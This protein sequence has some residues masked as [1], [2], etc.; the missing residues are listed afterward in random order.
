[1]IKDPMLILTEAMELDSTDSKETVDDEQLTREVE[2]VETVEESIIYTEEMI[3]VFHTSKGYIVE[4]DLLQKLIES[5][6]LQGEY[7]DE[8]KALSLL[9]EHNLLNE[10]IGVMIESENSIK[11]NLSR[12]KEQ[13]KK[14][15]SPKNKSIIKKRIDD[16][17]A[18]IQKLKSRG[19]VV[20]KK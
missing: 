14:E 16:T 2:E 1:M 17:T 20:K 10:D 18:L 9:Q 19:K 13:L 6:K 8:E 3:P 7:C 15:K 5:K 4:F 11:T 12:L